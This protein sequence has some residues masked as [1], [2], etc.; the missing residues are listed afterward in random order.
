MNL[1]LTKRILN[2]CKIRGPGKEWGYQ[3]LQGISETSPDCNKH[4]TTQ[5]GEEN[6]V[7][8]S[9]QGKAATLMNTIRPEE[10]SSH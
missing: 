8:K 9:F 1:N 10:T 5:K 7:E 4:M 3:Q 6:C 2:Y